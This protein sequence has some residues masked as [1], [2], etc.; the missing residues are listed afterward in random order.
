MQLL[1]LRYLSYALLLSA[2]TQAVAAPAPVVS[3]DESG[4]VARLE[5]ALEARNQMQLNMQQQ[6]DTMSAELLELR[7]DLERNSYTIQKMTADNERLIREL[8]ALK[9]IELPST[10]PPSAAPTLTP[11]PPN[12]E[13]KTFTYNSEPT[14]VETQEYDAALAYIL[15]TKDFEAATNA[16]ENFL[17]T[18]PNSSYTP[19]VHY[20]LG[21]LYFVENNYSTAKQYFLQVLDF[22]NSSKRPE[23]MVKLAMIAQKQNDRSMAID[24][25]NAVIQQYPFSPSADIAQKALTSV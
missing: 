16:F 5:R 4:D 11:T 18:Y 20:W 8:S 7:G 25:Y 13:N 15:K 17:T 3:L 12:V 14:P 22:P 19:N 2:A 21:Q 6:L 9:G 23:A 10:T 24:M 1:R